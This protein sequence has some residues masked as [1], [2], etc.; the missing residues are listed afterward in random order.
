MSDLT[1]ILAASLPWACLVC[2]IWYFRLQGRAFFAAI[3]MGNLVWCGA[4]WL[5]VQ[6][7][8]AANLV[9][10][11]SIHLVWIAYCLVLAVVFP[12]NR[13]SWRLPNPEKWW[14]IP[15]IIGCITLFLGLVYPPNNY[16]SLTYHLPRIAHWLQN[17]T[18]APWPT[19]IDRQIG[20]AP[21]NAILILQSWLPGNLNRFTNLPQW[22]AWLGSIF[23]IYHLALM[24]GAS[25]R[26]RMAAVIFFATL[27]VAI[28]QASNSDSCLL[29]TFHLLCMLWAYL[30][31]QGEDGHKW[32]QM[33]IFGVSLGFAI[34]SKGS[35]YPIALPFVLMVAWQCL[36]M[37]R[38][39]FWQG[40]LAAFLVIAINAPHLARNYLGEGSLVAS[41]ERNIITSPT[42]GTFLVNVLYNMVSNEPE[43]LGIGAKPI[44]KDIASR[45]GVEQDNTEI[46]PWGGLEAMPSRN[47]P[48]EGNVSNPVHILVLFIIFFHLRSLKPCRAYLLLALSSIFFFCLLLA[49]HPWMTRIQIPLFAM[50]AP[51]VGY[52]IAQ[53]GS[54]I[55]RGILLGSLCLS[56]VVPLL[57]CV[58]RPLLPAQ[59]VDFYRHDVRHFLNTS[60]EQLI[61]NY[62]PKAYAEYAAGV[63]ALAGLKPAKVAIDMGNNAPEYPLWHMLADRLPSLPKMEYGAPEKADCAFEYVRNDEGGQQRLRVLQKME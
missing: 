62:N 32:Q 56:A 20:M 45:L 39:L 53:T 37:P 57:L 48:A 14:W 17:H 6:L 13:I 9:Y 23:A 15:A 3:V 5:T 60:Q 63:D 36:K 49:W 46:L 30:L 8:S 12:R 19:G 25:K 40:A 16:D 31:W 11:A 41:S 2:T 50:A 24:L 59:L 58:E 18:L 52:A 42:P 7:L 54:R 43:L 33:A 35:A 10:P 47:V 22:F 51:P 29:V 4:I 44:L 21:W 28:L 61:F 26:A 34:L 38:K 55:R 27:P 1:K